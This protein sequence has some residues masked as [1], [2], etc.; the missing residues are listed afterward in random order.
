MCVSWAERGEGK[1]A[2]REGGHLRKIES[3]LFPPCRSFLYAYPNSP[4]PAT[5]QTGR[6]AEYHTRGKEA[7]LLK[8]PQSSKQVAPSPAIPR[9]SSGQATQVHGSQCSFYRPCV[10]AHSAHRASARASA[11][12]PA[13]AERRRGGAGLRGAGWGGAGRGSGGAGH[14]GAQAGLRGG[15]AGQG[16]GGPQEGGGVEEGRGGA[17]C[18]RG[19]ERAGP[20][21]GGVG[22]GGA[23]RGA[24]GALQ[25]RDEA[26]PGRGPRGFP[27]SAPFLHP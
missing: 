27:S 13:R 16:A 14:G 5:R 15:G 10:A 19:S 25:G 17:G 12:E 3:W 22:C 26:G 18:R 1:L 23:G 24:V 21:W 20:G 2:S 6:E 7:G 9:P 8:R 4:I 11:G